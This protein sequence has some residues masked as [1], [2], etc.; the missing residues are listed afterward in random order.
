MTSKRERDAKKGES[1][2]ATEGNVGRKDLSRHATYSGNSG[3]PRSKV[4]NRVM[5]QERRTTKKKR[6]RGGGKRTGEEGQ[7]RGRVGGSCSEKAPACGQGNN[8]GKRVIHAWRSCSNI[9]KRHRK[10][11]HLGERRADEKKRRALGAG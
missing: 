9:Q 1:G 11:V 10:G 5:V 4:R 6:G 8:E 7:R 2:R 3:G